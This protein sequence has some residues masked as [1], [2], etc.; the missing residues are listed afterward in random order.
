M[1]A[2]QMHHIANGDASFKYE[3]R[4]LS[5]YFFYILQRPYEHLNRKNRRCVASAVFQLSLPCRQAKM[6]AQ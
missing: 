6:P 5:D 2:K 1:F 3:M 4:V